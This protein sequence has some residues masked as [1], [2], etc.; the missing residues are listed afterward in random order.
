MVACIYSPSQLGAQKFRARESSSQT[1]PSPAKDRV[2]ELPDCGT[3]KGCWKFPKRAWKLQA[4]SLIPHPKHLFICI[5]CNSFHN[6]QVKISVFL[7]FMI[8][9]NKV[10]ETGLG[11][12]ETLIYSRSTG[13]T[14]WGLWLAS[15]SVCRGLWLQPVGSDAVTS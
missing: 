5:L 2:Q 3:C 12:V 10:I 9:S 15:R 8:H 1:K 14:S 13:K 4:P 6:K 11:F 7:S